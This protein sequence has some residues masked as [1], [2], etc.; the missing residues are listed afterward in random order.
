[1]LSRTFAPFS[2]DSTSN[3][4]LV[5]EYTATA[6]PFYNEG[7]DRGW[8]AKN[9]LQHLAEIVKIHVQPRQFD[10]IGIFV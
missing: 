2:T 7:G 8:D 3:L 10:T 5:H 9:S 6:T 4:W 1:M